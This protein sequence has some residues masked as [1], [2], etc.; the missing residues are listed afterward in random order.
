[1]KR[2]RVIVCNRFCFCSWVMNSLHKLDTFV[3][4]RFNFHNGVKHYTL[5]QILSPWLTR[6]EV[7]TEIFQVFV[8]GD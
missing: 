6:C 5:K 7:N 8:N 1:M 3:N 2:I 4:C